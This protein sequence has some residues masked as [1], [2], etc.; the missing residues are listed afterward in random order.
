MDRLPGLRSRMIEKLGKVAEDYDDLRGKE[1]VE[2]G[3]QIRSRLIQKRR[4]AE[5]KAQR[6][7][8][9]MI[10]LTAQTSA[11]QAINMS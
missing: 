2:I 4:D 11:L 1:G 5:Q 8:D 7:L 3:D 6:E 9:D 10:Q